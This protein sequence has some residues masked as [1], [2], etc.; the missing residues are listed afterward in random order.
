MRRARCWR[1]GGCVDARPGR[2]VAGQDAVVGA[3]SDR[4]LGVAES[5]VHAIQQG[6]RAAHHD[7]SL[8]R[9]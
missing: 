6:Q 8:A 7:P 4:H 2:R 1:Y 5:S 9:R 3:G